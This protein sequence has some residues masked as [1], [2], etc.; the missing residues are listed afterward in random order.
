MSFIRMFGIVS[1]VVGA[2]GLI[3]LGVMYL[4]NLRNPDRVTSR[5]ERRDARA[6][7]RENAMPMWAQ[8]VQV[9]LA[10]NALRGKLKRSLGTEYSPRHARPEGEPP[11]AALQS[12]YFRKYKRY[13]VTVGVVTPGMA[14]VEV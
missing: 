10:L 13:I 9:E 12:A 3:T 14:E 2:S 6:L 5:Q 1:I 8:L 7:R 11:T 4:G